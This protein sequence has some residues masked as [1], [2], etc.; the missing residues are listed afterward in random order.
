MLKDL[1][2]F[3]TVLM[4]ECLALPFSGLQV[5]DAVAHHRGV[6]PDGVFPENRVRMRTSEREDHAVVVLGAE[7]DR[8]GIVREPEALSA[9]DRAVVDSL[10]MIQ[11]Y[12]IAR[13][14]AVDV[15]GEAGA[16]GSGVVTG[17]NAV[18]N[19]DLV[20]IS[21]RAERCVGDFLKAD[22]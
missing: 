6:I 21:R 20:H 9:I 3:R 1:S 19:V 11:E 4:F 22:A 2:N 5:R 7:R 14:H 15:K 8:L 16:G 18:D 12:G 10:N 13:V 17:M